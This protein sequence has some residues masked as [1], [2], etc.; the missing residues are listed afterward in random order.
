MPRAPKATPTPSTEVDI[1][2]LRPTQPDPAVYD[3]ST[4]T[5]GAMPEVVFSA[6]APTLA[7][8]PAP[9]DAAPKSLTPAQ[10]ALAQYNASLPQA[11]D[12]QLRAPL[13]FAYKVLRAKLTLHDVTDLPGDEDNPLSRLTFGAVYSADE[14]NED[15]VFG[16]A[17]PYASYSLNVRR[18][19]AAHLEP[20]AAYY[21]DIQKVPT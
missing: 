1:Q 18:D 16:K 9:T 15:N 8:E 14:T 6:P 3:Y 19:L 4:G 7:A 10:D 21:V 2:D 11:E 13:R 20:G 5:D 12:A 17:T